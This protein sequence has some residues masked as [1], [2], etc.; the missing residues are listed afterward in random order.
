MMKV[1]IGFATLLLVVPSVGMAQSLGSAQSFAIVG[2]STATAAGTGSTIT[3]DVG[4]SPGTS[5]TGFDGTSATIVPPFAA[6][7]N[8]GQAIAAQTSTGALYTMLTAAGPCTPLGAQLNGVNVGP[9]VYCFTS[10][11]DLAAS[12]N[13]TLNGPGLYIFQVGSSLTANVL[14]TVTLL[15]GVDPCNVFWQVTSAA[16]LN[17]ANFVGNVVAQAGVT[18]GSGATLVGRALTTPAGAVTIAGSNSIGGCATAGPT[19]TA[20]GGPTPTSGLTATPV[21]TATGGATATPGGPTPTGGAT[22][23]PGGPTATPG[24]GTPRPTTSVS[25]PTRTPVFPPPPPPGTGVPTLS[26]WGLLGLVISLMAV[27]FVAL[28]RRAVGG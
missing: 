7:S 2:G 1:S 28:R 27:A 10:T 5:I 22:R 16:T 25:T 11:A 24:T 9:G 15:G 17:G 14:S 19:P 26:G 13:L 3:G 4:V 20:T 21:S 18:L 23:T 8:D 12:G 6:H